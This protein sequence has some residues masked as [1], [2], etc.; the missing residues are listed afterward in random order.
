[1]SQMGRLVDVESAFETLTG[2]TGGAVA[3]DGSGNLTLSGTAPLTTT[4][5]P[6]TNTITITH[7][8]SISESFPTDAG[9]AVPAAGALTIA[10]GIGVDTAGAGSTVTINVDGTVATSYTSDSGSATPAGNILTIV[11]GT[12]SVTSG[13]GSTVTINVDTDVAT[14]YASDSGSAIPA[15]NIITI[16]GGTNVSTS[17]TG[18][19][20]TVTSSSEFVDNA[21]RILDNGDNSKEIAFEASNITA[22]TTRTLT[23]VDANLDLAT[24]SNSFPTDAG[25]AAPTANA[26]TVAGGTNINTAGAGTTVTVNLDAAINSV[27]IGASTAS[28]GDFTSLSGTSITS[29]PGAASDSFLQ[30]DE[31]TTGKW[32]IGNDETDDSYRISQGSALGTNDTFIMTSAGE[33]TMPLNPSFLATHTANQLNVTGTGTQATVDY[34]T[35]ITDQ[36]SDY[37]GSNTFT[38]P[39]AGNY[40]FTGAVFISATG[41]AHQ[42][43]V[44]IVTSNRTYAGDL[45]TPISASIVGNI[46]VCNCDMD[47]ADTTYITAEATGTGADTANFAAAPANAYFCGV[48]TC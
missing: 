22:S 32:R 43:R 48:L 20:I 23:M 15:A 36:N 26:I 18:S 2:N 39:V 37:D 29:D 35:E 25:T 4:G 5:N 47:A 13:A 28:T 9:T 27:S 21:F 19:T 16:A 31:S 7:D 10:G 6:G 1:M 34:T 33:R 46:G 17:G 30:F 12:G 38:A 24:V 42:G 41:A 11:G 45:L 8:G 44:N 14:S 40:A 3:P